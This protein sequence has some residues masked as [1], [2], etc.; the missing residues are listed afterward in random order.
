[1]IEDPV[2]S[3]QQLGSLL[4]QGFDPRPGNFHVLG[5]GKISAFIFFFLF[6]FFF[7]LFRGAPAAHGN[8]H[9]MGL[10]EL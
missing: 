2:L 4:W 7:G 1:M 6:F 10:I 8:S 5:G 9:A 3:L